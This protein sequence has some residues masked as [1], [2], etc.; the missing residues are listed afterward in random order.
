[1]DEKLSKIEAL[2]RAIL[3]V[4]EGNQ[5]D[6]DFYIISHHK[7][8][9]TMIHKD[10]CRYVKNRY[11]QAEQQDWSDYFLSFTEAWNEAKRIAGEHNKD[12]L[13]CSVCL[14]Q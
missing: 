3:I 12:P 10:S 2:S 7:S 6:L 8:G 5:I 11:E 4:A 9:R 13:K 14:P 1:M